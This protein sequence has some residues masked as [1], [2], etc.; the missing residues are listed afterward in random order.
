VLSE[1]APTGRLGE[2]GLEVDDQLAGY[3][4]APGR[5]RLVPRARRRSGGETGRECRQQAGENDGAPSHP[6]VLAENGLELDP[7]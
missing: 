5:H 3:V 6:I 7:Y 1:D 4:W 2:A